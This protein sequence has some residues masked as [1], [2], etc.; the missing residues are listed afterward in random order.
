MD[1]IPEFLNCF[2]GFCFAAAKPGYICSI[3]CWHFRALSGKVESG[4][5]SESA[6]EKNLEQIHV[7]MKHEFAL[8]SGVQDSP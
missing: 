3:P 7:S 6:S 5:P 1:A 4:F 2:T 8:G